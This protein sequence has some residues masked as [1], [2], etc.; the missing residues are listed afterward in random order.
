[1]GKFDH[2]VVHCKKANYDVY[3]GRPSKWGNPF[4]H[5]PSTTLAKYTCVNR[6]CRKT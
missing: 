4:T 3:I 2:L 6:G 1:M 5:L